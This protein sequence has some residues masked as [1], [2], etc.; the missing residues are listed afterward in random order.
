MIVSPHWP[1]IRVQYVGFVDV[2]VVVVDVAMVA[3]YYYYCYYRSDDSCYLDDL[4]RERMI[5][6]RCRRQVVSVDDTINVD[7]PRPVTPTHPSGPIVIPVHNTDPSGHH[8]D[9]TI[10]I[11][12]HCY[13][14]QGDGRWPD[15][16]NHKSSTGRDFD[17]RP[18]GIR[19]RHR[20][21]TSQSQPLNAVVAGAIS[22]F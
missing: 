13:D 17:R 5:R 22:S 11:E 9:D 3:E 14:Y 4:G 16:G 7:A 12:C 18:N 10:I 2:P 1:G 20:T 19:R 15:G 21:T 8:N 6:R